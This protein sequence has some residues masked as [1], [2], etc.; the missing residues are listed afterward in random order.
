M[1]EFCLNL[2]QM[3]AHDFAIC[4]P[5]KKPPTISE[6]HLT[7]FSL[8]QF[9]FLAPREKKAQ[10][11]SLAKREDDLHGGGASLQHPVAMETRPGHTGERDQEADRQ[12][13]PWTNF[14]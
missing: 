6:W 2:I 3:R 10:V 14:S 4:I 12:Y 13:N 1:L 8:V 9:P 5:L 11:H 7:S